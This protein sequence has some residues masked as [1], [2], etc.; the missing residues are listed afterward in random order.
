MSKDKKEL[1]TKLMD[2]IIP[3]AIQPENSE[4]NI[5]LFIS[6]ELDKFYVS[7][8]AKGQLDVLDFQ[9]SKQSK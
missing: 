1:I 4:E 2:K 3:V 9:A 6:H 7:V 5:R 8:F